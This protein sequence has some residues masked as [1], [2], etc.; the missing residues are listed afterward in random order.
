MSITVYHCE[1]IS[2]RVH[3][4]NEAAVHQRNAYLNLKHGEVGAVVS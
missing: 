3:E 2:S 1:G 4:L